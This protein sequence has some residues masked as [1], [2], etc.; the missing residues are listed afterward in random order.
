MKYEFTIMELGLIRIAL[1]GTR[2]DGRFLEKLGKYEGLLELTEEEEGTT[3]ARTYPEGFS[4]PPGQEDTVV[5]REVP[6]GALTLFQG[7]ADP[8]KGWEG[9]FRK[10]VLA[11]LAKLKRFVKEAKALKA[12]EGLSKEDRKRLQEAEKLKEEVKDDSS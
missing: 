12:Y 3:G 10:P 8:Y 11:L 7:A 5:E 6:Q 4:I 9:R 2:G 1:A